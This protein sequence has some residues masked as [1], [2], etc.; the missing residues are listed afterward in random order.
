MYHPA[1][2]EI[3]PVIPEKTL[4][5]FHTHQ[6]NSVVYLLIAAAFQHLPGFDIIYA[7]SSY[8]IG[9]FVIFQSPGRDCPDRRHTH[10][11]PSLSFCLYHITSAE[12]SNQR[13]ESGRLVGKKPLPRQSFFPLEAL[14]P[15]QGR[16]PFGAY[17]K[18]AGKRGTPGASG[19]FL[20]TKNRGPGWTIPCGRQPSASV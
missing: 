12:K 15:P 14:F 11:S 6:T 3:I 20:H 10:I 5:P 8:Q 18:P 1:V 7:H 4:L 13:K 19:G 2:S 9:D 17:Q 16:K